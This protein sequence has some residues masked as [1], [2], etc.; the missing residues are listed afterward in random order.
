VIRFKK[1]RNGLLMILGGLIALMIILMGFIHYTSVRRSLISDYRE[2][3]L[4]TSLQASQSSLQS[5]LE[6]AIETSEL[7]AEDP[8]LMVWFKANEKSSYTGQLVL[9]RLDYLH[10]SYNYASVFAVNASTLNYWRENY[11][12]LDV[13]S[14]YDPD[15]N[16]FFEAIEKK[17]KRYLNFD[18]NRELKQAILFVNVLMGDVNDPIGIAGVGVDPSV[19]IHTFEKHKLTEHS[20]VWLIDNQGVVNMSEDISMINRSLANFLPRDI[21][22]A[23]LRDTSDNLIPDQR[24][25]QQKTEIAYMEV[26]DTGYKVVM[27]VPMDELLK[28]LGIIRFNFLWMSLLI[29]I[30]TLVVVVWLSRSVSVPLG[31]LT[32]LAGNFAGGQLKKGI[33]RE[34][35]E[36]PDEIGTLANA[37]ETMKKQ[38][39]KVIEKVRRTNED[40]KS[41]KQEL[42]SVNQKLKVALEK[43]SESDRLTR[44]FLAN[45]SH[46]IRTP[47][48]SILGFAQLL[49]LEDVAEKDRTVYAKRVVK[50]GQQ[51]LSILDNVINL[52]K[53]DSGIIQPHWQLVDINQLMVD[54][55]ELFQATALQSGIQLI[56]TRQ[57]EH[58]VFKVVSDPILLQQVLNNLLTNAIKFTSE[59]S[60]KL[61]YRLNGNMLRFY[62]SDTGSGIPPSQEEAIFEPFHQVGDS[63]INR[64]GAGLG[65]AIS[66][67]I[68][69][70]LHGEIGIESTSS[71]GSTF[72][73]SLPV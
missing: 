54:T 46:E 70:I 33:D 64:G 3:H 21:V 65:L 42:V 58:H 25:K 37:F 68:A 8:T 69:G 28:S 12:L 29:F 66:S 63:T 44:S 36:R 23:V 57:T 1:I 53:I 4:L 71:E 11:N 6:R 17:E 48:N 7:L 20:H 10:K 19:L 27:A 52:S 38:L 50:G 22:D 62:V 61:G 72:Y 26:G 49:E 60:V 2:K 41:E 39:T 47:M 16:W 51:L 32:F 55:H 15:D 35:L 45:I 14:P 40:L 43:A 30:I 18:Y 24:V 67:K 31:R 59:G 9:Q 56:H 5:I 13:V 73:F 34:L